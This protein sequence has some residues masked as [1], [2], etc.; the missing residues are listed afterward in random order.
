MFYIYAYECED[1]NTCWH[2]YSFNISTTTGYVIS[3]PLTTK[4]FIYKL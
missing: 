2:R 3:D 4:V 1:G